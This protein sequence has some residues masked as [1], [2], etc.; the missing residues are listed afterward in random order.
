MHLRDLARDH[1]LPF[2]AQSRDSTATTSFSRLRRLIKN[3]VR[4]EAFLRFQISCRSPLLQAGN[5]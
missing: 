4:G 5:R 1:H 3:L 2:S